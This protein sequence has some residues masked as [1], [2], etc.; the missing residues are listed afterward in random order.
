[1]SALRWVRDLVGKNRTES[2][3]QRQTSRDLP[4]GTE[5]GIWHLRRLLE[6]YG[7]LERNEKDAQLKKMIPLFCKIFANRA[8]EISQRF[9]EAGEFAKEIGKSLVHEVQT[10]AV[11]RTS[12]EACLVIADY[13][14]DHSK[15]ASSSASADDAEVGASSQ[16]AKESS[17]DGWNMLRAIRLLAE[18]LS[19]S[20]LK[21][22]A[23]CGLPST[24]TKC[25]YVFFDLPP[26]PPLPPTPAGTESPE[27]VPDTT[28][29][30]E[31]FAD[32]PPSSPVVLDEMQL[33]RLRVMHNRR[34]QLHAE[35][36]RVLVSLCQCVAGAEDIT[37]KDDLCRLFGVVTSYCPRHCMQW[38]K[39]S[40]DVLICIARCSLSPAIVSYVHRRSCIPLCVRNMNKSL[41]EGVSPLELIEMFVTLSCFIKDASETSY[42]LLDDF[43]T[44]QGYRFLADFL[45]RIEVSSHNDAAHAM[46]NMVLLVSNLTKTGF[47]ELQPPKLDGS[48]FQ[49]DDFVM[50]KPAGTGK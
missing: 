41:T 24:L 38:R 31:A 11:N 6:D 26:L 8:N 44:S 29:S 1:M 4:Q 39:L 10:R 36:T 43:R 50:P 45:L 37:A 35:V 28:R 40:S 27:G 7:K 30:A 18:S 9:P 14:E 34:I 19:P 21:T 5:L 2:P 25:L 32:S 22:L 49:A 17:N 46:R 23:L 15:D 42:V 33:A 3:S 20:V 47:V 12:Q 48:P 13:L 16:K